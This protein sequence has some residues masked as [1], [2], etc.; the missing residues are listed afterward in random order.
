MLAEEAAKISLY[1]LVPASAYF[2]FPS[3]PDS[4]SIMPQGLGQAPKPQLDIDNIDMRT[5]T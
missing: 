2:T 5:H 4:I 3:E 1:Q